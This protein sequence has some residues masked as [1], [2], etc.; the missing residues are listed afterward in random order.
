MTITTRKYSE[1]SLW[2]GNPRPAASAQ[3]RAEM[4]ASLLAQGQ[5][6]PLITRPTAEGSQII[7]G[8][9]RYVNIGELIAEG[10]WDEEREIVVD[11]RDLDDTEALEIATSENIN[12][13]MHPMHQ[14]EAFSRLVEMGRSPT[15]IANGYGVSVRIVEQ[16]LSYAKLALRAREMV[17]QNERDLEWASAMTMASP[18]EQ[19]QILDEIETEPRRYRTAHEIRS[20]LQ[21]ELIPLDYALFDG[22]GVEAGQVRRDLFD[23]ADAK[24]MKK[25]DFLPLQEQALKSLVKERRNEGWNSVEVQSHREFDIYRYA[26]G[27]TDKAKSGVIFVRYDSGEVI[28]HAGLVLRQDERVNEISKDDQDA[29][30]SIFGDAAAAIDDDIRASIQDEEEII[31]YSE[32]KKTA[33]HLE[34]ERA[35]IVQKILLENQHLALCATV[36]GLISNVASRP[37]EGRPFQGLSGLDENGVAR[38]A[39]Q[40]KIETAHNI[41]KVH[42]VDPTA[43]Y[44]EVMQALVRLSQDEILIVFQTELARRIPTDMPRI[45]TMYNTLLDLS[46]TNVGDHWKIDRTF[47]STLSVPSLR[48]LANDVLPARLAS[49]SGKSKG[50]LVETIAQIADDAR[51]DGGRLGHIER[52]A[53]NAWAPKA[54]GGAQPAVLSDPFGAEKNENTDSNE[55]AE[56]FA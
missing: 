34:V 51:E 42:G 23:P 5:I 12:I 3:E 21:D 46:G 22:S 54:L 19:E 4:K 45:E 30:E 43:P 41:L 49:R 52:E 2:D 15:E 14:Y 38:L 56:I 36:A 1:L 47:L 37:L 31:S 55:G 25:S 7:A 44:Q 26:D 18:S 32:T 48:G 10:S 33:K 20:R 13:A 9:N 8:Q 40:E 39:I 53:L 29:A 50:D 6:M 24:Y 16:R 27:A 17:K 35:A 28:E 11:E